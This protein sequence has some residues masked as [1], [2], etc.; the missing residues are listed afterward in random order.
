MA[1]E[2]QYSSTVESNKCKYKGQ[3]TP[4]PPSGRRTTGFS[5]PI[6]SQSSNFGGQAPPLYKQRA[7]EITT[8]LFNNAEPKRPKVKNGSGFDSSDGMMNVVC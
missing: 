7:Q 1:E 3:T 4:S 6:A 5:T 8:R 2:V